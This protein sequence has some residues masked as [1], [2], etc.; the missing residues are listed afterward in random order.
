MTVKV[1]VARQSSVDTTVLAAAAA[2]AVNGQSFVSELNASLITS[3]VQ[4]LLPAGSYV[5]AP[6]DMI[7]QIIPQDR[8]V[9]T[10]TVFPMGGQSVSAPGS[11]PNFLRSGDA[12][13]VPVNHS[14]AVSPSTVAFFTDST[15][16]TINMETL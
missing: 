9:G 5:R 6:I 10:L 8:P 12:L 13:C 7:G 3:A 1:P 4:Q 14:I 11:V 16:I 15:K 2:A